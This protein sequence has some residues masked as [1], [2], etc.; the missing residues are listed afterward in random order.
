MFSDRRRATAWLKKK[1]RAADAARAVVL[2][3]EELEARENPAPVAAVAGLANVTPFL[4][5]DATFSF[6][7][8]NTSGT[9]VGYSPF[10]DLILETSGADGTTN[11]PPTSLNPTTP[12]TA[13]DGFAPSSG[14]PV[15]PTV[16]ASGLALAPVGTPIV[17]TAGQTTYVNPFT[18]QTLAVP[19]AFGAGDTVFTYQLPFGSFTPGQSTAVKVTAP[20]SAL[21]DLGTP[22][23]L[24]VRPGFRDTDGNPNPPLVPAVYADAGATATPKLYDL[25]K[26]YQGPENETATG[27][28]YVRRY[29]LSVDIATGQT[30]QG[31][32]VT[33]DL[34]ATMQIVGKSATNMSAFLASSGLGTNVFSA[35]N[36]TGT[37]V[38]TAPD[39]TLVYNFGSVTGVAGVD[40]VFEFDFYV[41]RDNSSGAE[42][43]PQPT[44]PAPNPATGTDSLT[45][46]STTSATGTT[47]TASS[48]GTWNPLDSRDPQGVNVAKAAPDNGPHTLQEQSLATQKSATLIDPATGSTTTSALPGQTLIRYD[49]DFQVSDYYAFQNL[50]L[51]DLVGDGQRL[52]LGTFGP[53][54]AQSAA[55]TLSINNA[56]VKNGPR[57]NLAAQAFGSTGSIQY[58][59]L[60]TP[61]ANSDPTGYAPAGPSSAVF[62]NLAAIPGTLA[63][64]NPYDGSTF[65]QFNISQELDRRLPAGDGE[66]VGGDIA[67]NG[68]GPFNNP[69]GSQLFSGTTGRVTFY[70]LTTKE[71]SDVFQL[72]NG[73]SGDPSVDQGDKL[74]NKVPLDGSADAQ[75]ANGGAA[76]TGIRGDQV[77]P[78]TINAASPTVIGV[79]TD[80]TA[81][82][83]TIASGVQTK[84]VYAINDTLIPTQ[85]VADTVFSLQ[86]GDRVTYKL[87]Y[88]L[89][90]SRFESLQLLDTPPLPV[91]AVGPVAN[92]TFDRTPD[93]S[94]TP[95]EIEVAPDDTFFS[96]FDGTSGNPLFPSLVPGTTIAT[97]ATTN[98]ITMSFGNFD[99]PQ[100]RFTT[101]SLLVTLPVSADPFVGDLFLTNQLRVN[102]GNTFLGTTTVEDLRRVQLV[103]PVVTVSKGIVGF[104]ATGRTL[105]GIAFTAPNDPP[106]GASTPAFTGTLDTAG[107]AAAVGAANIATTDN[108]DANDRVRYAI[109]A[110]NT[111][112]GDAYDVVI[113]DQVQ[114]GYVIPPT[115]AGLNL[116]VRRGDGTLLA[117]FAEVQGFARVA[118]TGALTGAGLAFSAGVGG[119]QFTNVDRLFDG[120]TLNLNDLVLVKNQTGASQNGVYQVTAVDA[121]TDR[122]TLT[123]AAAFD[124]AAELSQTF[125]AV[126][127]GTSANRYF[128]AGAV[129]TLNTSAV[130]YTLQATTQDYYAIYDPAGGAFR[131]LL[132]DN[133]TAGNVSPANQVPD[134]RAGSLSRA[135]S[136][137]LVN[138]GDNPT[139]TP[140]TNGSN[141]VV[142]QYDLVLATTVTPNQSITNTARVSAYGT[143][144]GGPDVTDQAVVP[145]ATDPTDTAT[146]V[147]EL[148]QQTKALIDTE[149]GSLTGSV[150][151]PT[152][153]NLSTS[154]EPGNGDTQAV[155]GELITYEI[156]LTIPEG[157]TP[158]A[159]LFDQLGEGLALVDLTSVTLSSGLSTSNGLTVA[160]NGAA[161]AATLTTNTTVGGSN[162]K[163]I[164]FGL[165]TITNTGTDNAV[166]E[167]ITIRYR[168]VVLNANSL[169]GDANG[170]QAAAA[171]IGKL[172]RTYLGRLMAKYG[173]R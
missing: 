145:G 96:T 40:A 2:R 54:G 25:I 58:R 158:G 135:Q 17:L 122:V 9:D 72:A 127:G 108:V 150:P 132:S 104:G 128:Q 33:D 6:T 37:A 168:A 76:L 107:E 147:I 34:A 94:F 87:T 111:G 148:P 124:T 46:P 60:F 16:T 91:L 126:M 64:T 23:D 114:P 66:L 83:L 140:I 98:T 121:A 74:L 159:D 1:L 18:G 7:F 119:G 163:N 79:G 85:T 82:A 39:G 20:T 136:T 95:Y 109:V 102:E 15:A 81:T 133:Y 49:I 78:A 137:P 10:F 26:T 90:I 117:N 14:A 47:N 143:S 57:T 92:Y 146:A 73:G 3:V 123:R 71:Y 89:P 103:R 44:P 149:I 28:N 36:L 53:G 86:A 155:I 42:I 161:N 62:T 67:N 24:T 77:A 51:Q 27:P 75:A 120:A 61:G 129:T 41:P 170:N 4:G 164:T 99:D 112:R 166:A 69:V 141:T 55:P 8:T 97:N 5:D 100:D 84:T 110:Q 173:L 59:Q 151:D 88:T 21:A 32:Q 106:T 162:N 116:N 101:I 153:G 154:A 167:T 115:F 70:A 165:G 169:P 22:L 68:T 125:V 160:N 11:L 131:L 38:T 105:G 156:V 31:L 93:G 19:A 152:G 30:I 65:L 52:Y 172:D 29:R 63:S 144:E 142:V 134:D 45:D 56:F 118:T 48:A 35:G 171:R 50:T 80:D 130:N 43:L 138:A 13:A 139:V 157:M 12:G 113:E